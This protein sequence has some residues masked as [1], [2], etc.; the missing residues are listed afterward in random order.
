MLIIDYNGPMNLNDSSRNASTGLEPSLI[1]GL[2]IESIIV[3][4]RSNYYSI[5]YAIMFNL[6]TSVVY[7]VSNR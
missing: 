2:T 6:H 3:N 7:Y 5:P 1:V 4:I